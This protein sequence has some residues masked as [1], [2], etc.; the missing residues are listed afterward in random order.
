MA[1]F[2]ADNTRHAAVAGQFYPDDPEQLAY[3]TDNYIASAKPSKTRG[4]LVA[5]LAPHAGFVFS[6]PVAGYTYRA[7]QGQDVD[8]AI[9]IGLCHGYPLRGASIYP[10][11]FF[12]TPLGKVPINEALA[13]KIM[14][15]SSLIEDIPAAHAGEHSLETQLPFLQRIFKKITIVPLL[16][17]NPSLKICKEIGLAIAAAVKQERVIVIAS[18]DMSHFPSYADA[19]RLDKQAIMSILTLKPEQLDSNIDRLMNEGAGNVSCVMCGAGANETTMYA[20][21]ALG[22]DSAALLKYANSGDTAGSKDRV[23]GYASVIFTKSRKEESAMTQENVVFSIQPE[24]QKIL[25]QIARKSIAAFIKEKKMP[26]VSAREDSE[27]QGLAAVFVTLTKDNGNLRGCIGTTEARYPLIDAVNQLAVSAAFQDPRFSPVA[28]SE[29]P[30]IHIEISVLSPLKQIQSSDE[31]TPGVHG[32]VVERNGNAGLFLPQVW[33]HF[34]NDK[35]AFM[36]ELCSQ[37]AGLPRDSW[38]KDKTIK[39]YTF[40]VFAFEEVKK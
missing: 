3:L 21:Q 33:E 32:V 9:L 36:G 35:E 5:C 22:A 14:D 34:P 15:R 24:N 1:A 19:V 31:I 7:L 37:K 8:T 40:T 38:K 6:G 20:A 39:I 11:G 29:L 4:T 16:I 23:V 30:D 27:L 12:E 28:E 13:K 17:G 18:S 26:R 10:R 25:L 2:S